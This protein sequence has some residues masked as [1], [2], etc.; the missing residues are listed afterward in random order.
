MCFCL[1]LSSSLPCPKSYSD[2][3]AN[4]ALSFSVPFVGFVIVLNALPVFL[5]ILLSYCGC[6]DGFAHVFWFVAHNFI[7]YPLNL[8]EK[9]AIHS[10]SILL[11]PM[12]C[13]WNYSNNRKV[14][15]FIR[16]PKA[17]NSTVSTIFRK[18]ATNFQNCCP[19][20]SNRI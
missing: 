1:C 10:V 20:N 7:A 16:I 18:M 3:V 6:C 4:I 17:Q 13:C 19:L 8:L 11:H 9:I 5:W 15:N 2:L 12:A 14:I